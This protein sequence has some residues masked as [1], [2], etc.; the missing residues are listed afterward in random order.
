MSLFRNSVVHVGSWAALVGFG[1]WAYHEPGFE[2]IIGLI[3]GAVGIVTNFE[4]FPLGRGNRRK[5]TPEAKI[6]LRDKWRPVFENF[7]LIAARDSYRTDVIVHDVAR[8]DHYPDIDEK[9][10][11]ISAW[12]RVGLMG[13]YNRG[14][15]LGLRWTFLRQE[16]NGEW[17]EY[18][19]HPPEDA[20][21][22]M[23]LAEMP[24]ELIESFTPDGDKFYNKPHLFCHFDYGGQPYERLFYGEQTQLFANSPYHYT[25]I[26]EFKPPPFLERLKEKY[27]LF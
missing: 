20:L 15:L 18:L 27:R 4:D 6:A 5:L 3:A 22:V 16:G 19:S 2:P 10:Q 13:T 14:V 8:L 17:V 26:A 25:E 24:Y 1:L 9:S 23:L 12:F 21:K 11:G 7:F